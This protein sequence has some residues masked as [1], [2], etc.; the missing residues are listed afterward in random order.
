MG[1]DNNEWWLKSV[2]VESWAH[3]SILGVDGSEG[4]VLV[5]MRRVSD[6]GRVARLSHG[7]SRA[8][9]IGGL[10]GAFCQGTPSVHEWHQEEKK[11]KQG[12]LGTQE[13]SHICMTSLG[14]HSR[15]ILGG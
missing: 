1:N 2:V 15:D 8:P 11:T 5:E 7:P 9:W 13:A 14:L 4:A 6:H 10:V 3:K 12:E